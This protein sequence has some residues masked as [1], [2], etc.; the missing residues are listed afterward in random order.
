MLLTLERSGEFSV[1]YKHDHWGQCGPTNTTDVLQYSVKLV[2][3]A[4]ALDK[5]G[6]VID[7]FKVQEYFHNTYH[8]VEDFHSCEVI[9]IKAVGD[10]KWMLG[11]KLKRIECTIGGMPQ[12]KLTATEQWD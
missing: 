8:E 9:A 11:H 5:D 1:R 2:M 12:A 6:F 7:N 10:F 3:E 4:G